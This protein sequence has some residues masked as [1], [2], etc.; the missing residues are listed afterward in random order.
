MNMILHEGVGIKL[1]SV[2]NLTFRKI[3]EVSRPVF[4]VKKDVLA[5]VSSGDDVIQSA[6]KMDT[7]FASHEYLLS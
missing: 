5:L 7:W 4:I 2:S 3:R 6:W 1:N